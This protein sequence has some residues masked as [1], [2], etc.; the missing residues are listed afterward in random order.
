MR[1]CLRSKLQLPHAP[2]KDPLTAADDMTLVEA[3]WA[4]EEVIPPK[5]HGIIQREDIDPSLRGPSRDNSFNYS[6]MENGEGAL[7]TGE[8]LTRPKSGEGVW[9]PAHYVLE[10]GRLLVF[11]DRHHIRPKQVPVACVLLVRAGGSIS[12]EKGGGRGER[13]PKARMCSVVVMTPSDSSWCTYVL[14][15]TGLKEGSGE[16]SGNAVMFGVP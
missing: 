12:V 14:E 3:S 4:E 9:K 5:L 7:L 2:P 10:K 1:K 15:T 6:G 16:R 11:E 13:E 8:L